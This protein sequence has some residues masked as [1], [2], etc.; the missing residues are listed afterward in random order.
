MP[1]KKKPI[2]DDEKSVAISEVKSDLD[3]NTFDV[4]YKY[5]CNNSPTLSEVQRFFSEPKYINNKGDAS[6]NIVDRFTGRSFKIPD[7]RLSTMFKLLEA[8][9][10][11]KER[12]MFNER[13]L[14]PSGLM[15]DFDIYQDEEKSQIDTDLIKQLCKGIIEI[16]IKMLD[17]NK[18]ENANSEE[19][20][21]KKL[22]IFI[23]ITRRP[24][25]SFVDERGAF[26]DGL[27]VLIPGIKIT[28]VI[29]RLIIN[30]MIN[31]E[32]IDRWFEEV[33]PTKQK[34]NNQVFTRRDFM[35]K[36]SGH[37]PVHF[38]GCSTKKGAAPYQLAHIFEVKINP[39][40]G[41][42]LDIIQRNSLIDDPTFNVMH[43]FSI[44]YETPIDTRVIHKTV[45]T[46][47]EKYLDEMREL[48]TKN[49]PQEEEISRNYGNLSM[50]SLHDIRA[51]EILELLDIL[52][53][54]RSES[55]DPWFNVLCVLANMPAGYKDLA[56]YFSRKSK[57]FNMADFEHRWQ[58]IIKGR[59]G[60]R[61][62]TIASLHH[63]A[64]EDNP[65]KYQQVRKQQIGA[66]IYGM[67]NEIYK[68]G[69]LGHAD[70]A[71]IVYDILKHKY[72]TDIPEGDRKRVW[73][74]FI[75]E[76]DSDYIDG[77]LFKWSMT[78]NAPKSL[79]IYISSILPN[80]FEYVLRDIKSQYDN[81]TDSLSKYLL[82]V[83]NNL[84]ATMRSF[85]NRT[86]KKYVLDELEELF[87]QKGFCQDLDKDPLVRGVQNGVLKLTTTPG[88]RPRLIR[89]YHSHKI[90]KY[91]Q[92]PYIPF[93]PYDPITKQIIIALRNLY[94]DD[95]PDSFEFT[96]YY[97]ASTIDGNPKESMF[98]I[99]RGGGGNGKTFI[100]ELH[101]AAIGPIYGVKMPLSYLT[102]KSSNAD[103]ATPAQMQLK[104]A[105]LATY[106]ESNQMEVLNAA[107]VKEVTGLETIAGRKLHKDMVNF[108]PKCHHLVTTNFDFVIECNDH[109]TWRRIIYNPLKIKFVDTDRYKLTGDPYERPCNK[110]FAE[111]WT[112]DPEVQG[113]YYGY[114]VWMHYW[115]YMKY[116]GHVSAV[117]HPHIELET[118]K[119]RCRQDTISSFLAQRCVKTADDKTEHSLI[120]EM[121][122]Y[123]RW[124]SLNH[125]SVVVAKGVQDQFLNSK[126]AKHIRN[127][128]RGYQI[129]GYRFLDN[130]QQPEAGED[131]AYK[132]IF[133][134]AVPDDNFGIKPESAEEYHARLCSEYDKNKSIFD[135]KESYDTICDVD[136][137]EYQD[138]GNFIPPKS[139]LTKDNLEK[140][141]KMI[142]QQTKS[143]EQ[144]YNSMLKLDNVQTD[145]LDNNLTRP[146]GK[147]I[148]LSEP[149]LNDNNKKYKDMQ[150]E[151]LDMAAD[152]PFTDDLDEL[153]DDEYDMCHK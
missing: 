53:P 151:Y 120:D 6:T 24:K 150:R 39:L 83:M 31:E 118:E 61:V 73:F 66:K 44:N 17:F 123:I 47:R 85:S 95:E 149:L 87:Q 11:N 9:R 70:V 142:E 65:E 55:Y 139:M 101:K 26:K 37:V 2:Q 89:G 108:K 119:Y 62:Y 57:R 141:T 82:K 58:S 80:M 63:W 23:G 72:I 41:E 127:T 42:I 54:N 16:L 147:L 48:E 136:G 131:Y 106:S 134:M 22:S 153:N 112:E 79:S 28:R 15:L 1:P 124:Y 133:D 64:K 75:T 3:P 13:Q 128:T 129:V 97:L 84:K 104:E 99:M 86:F 33:K 40:R 143:I 69:I 110:L 113:R 74:E 21:K 138:S 38:I 76:D 121:Q 36:N 98:M 90:S 126:M 32:L 114:M 116:G 88:C 140:H 145:N 27:H 46:V 115:L 19:S 43:E 103:N 152:H 71:S 93:N 94:A 117:P 135:T 5:Q 30:K 4:T 34:I 35:D 51:K 78:Y 100:V 60:R 125:G 50:H 111:K 144:Q 7:Q 29:K 67:V 148:P 92:V 91:T 105:S 96:M 10:R 68:E 109:G 137:N 52:S 12:V 8:C 81:A 107:R 20:K 25:V 18:G 77:E 45:Y 102:N 14:E 49:Q 146:L 122:K 56:E 132:N 59:K 130:N